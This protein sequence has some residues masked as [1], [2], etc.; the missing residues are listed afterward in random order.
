MASTA[1]QFHRL[2]RNI[3]SFSDGQA[4]ICS[5][6]I[7]FDI[8]LKEFVVTIAPKDGPYRGGT[9]EF[10]VHL[11]DFPEKAPRVECATPIHHP[12]I[13]TMNCSVCLNLLDQDWE[14]SVTLEDVVQGLLFLMHNP[15]TSDPLNSHFAI[16]M[17][18]IPRREFELNVRKTL[19][20]GE[21]FGVEFP[22]NLDPAY[23]DDG[24]TEEELAVG[25]R[26]YGDLEPDDE[27]DEDEDAGDDENAEDDDGSTL[28]QDPH[29]LRS[30]QSDDEIDRTTTF[31]I[32]SFDGVDVTGPLRRS[33][34]RLPDDLRRM[35]FGEMPSL[36]EMD[37]IPAEQGVTLLSWRTRAGSP[38]SHNRRSVRSLH[39]IVEEADGWVGGR[40]KRSEHDGHCWN[41]LIWRCEM[42][43]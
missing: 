43:H 16:P 13:H 5:E 8:E 39:L 38:A 26:H 7:D 18:S 31:A 19:R 22:R 14:P 28:V 35:A 33:L 24:V 25:C 41:W 11:E 40:T 9:F 29:E 12:N 42:R 21:H 20:G 3:Q 30:S 10:I 32:K 23:E 2:L 4:S 1:K 15:N 36:D 34:R 17:T 27:L 6:N 37:R